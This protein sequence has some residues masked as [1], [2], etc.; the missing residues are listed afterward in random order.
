MQPLSGYLDVTRAAA[1]TAGAG[2]K[3][4]IACLCLL[5]A[6]NG[7]PEVLSSNG[8]TEFS[9]A[10]TQEFFTRWKVQHCLSSA[11]YPQSNGRAE[12]AVKSAKRLLRDHCTP[13]G[14]LNTD[15]YMLAIMSH[16]N[17]R[18][19]DTGKVPR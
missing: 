19:K 1:G 10:E 4:L 8:G 2:A 7:I 5:F 16:R 3:G 17:T 14:H 18:D 15:T 6:D 9:A 13:L 11:H 12:V